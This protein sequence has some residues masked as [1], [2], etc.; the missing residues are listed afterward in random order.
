MCKNHT[1]VSLSHSLFSFPLTGRS[2]HRTIFLPDFV[3][4]AKERISVFSATY[5]KFTVPSTEVLV[6]R[7]DVFVVIDLDVLVETS[8]LKRMKNLN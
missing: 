6:R 8:V 2:S 3:I 1:R 7:L 4:K 5:T